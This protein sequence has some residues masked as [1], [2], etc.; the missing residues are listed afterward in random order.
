M[1]DDMPLVPPTIYQRAPK[2]MPVSPQPPG[3]CPGCK[4]NQ[5]VLVELLQRLKMVE[6][7]CAWLEERVRML[8]NPRE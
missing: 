4:V 6:D 5:E 8:E 7:R 1:A 3:M 2:R